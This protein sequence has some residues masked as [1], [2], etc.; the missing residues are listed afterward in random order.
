MFCDTNSYR[1]SLSTN[2]PSPTFNFALLWTLYFFTK[3]TCHYVA[4]PKAQPP[5]PPQRQSNAQQDQYQHLSS[6][7]APGL[8]RERRSPCDLPPCKAQCSRSSQDPKVVPKL[9]SKIKSLRPTP[10]LNTTTCLRNLC[11]MH[12]TCT[13]YLNIRPDRRLIIE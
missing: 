1:D 8:L 5:P 3:E 9:E 12:G 11:T 4:K 7:F 2:I 6:A 10:A 13:S